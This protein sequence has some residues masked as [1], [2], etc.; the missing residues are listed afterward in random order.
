MAE[1]RSGSGCIYRNKVCVTAYSINL[2]WTSSRKFDIHDSRDDCYYIKRYI[3]I[4]NV[5]LAETIGIKL[6]AFRMLEYYANH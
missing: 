2:C 6:G 1:T 5:I 4:S 3:L